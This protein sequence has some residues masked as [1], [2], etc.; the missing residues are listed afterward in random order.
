MQKKV[1]KQ[2]KRRRSF[3]TDEK[4][5]LKTWPGT[6]A[7]IAITGHTATG[8][9]KKH[10]TRTGRKMEF[11]SADSNGS[12]AS[13]QNLLKQDVRATAG[14]QIQIVGLQETSLLHEN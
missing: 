9:A 12:W 7:Q 4:A 11:W 8:Q 5:E 14:A 6:M 2:E 10:K 3:D 13:A 1:Q